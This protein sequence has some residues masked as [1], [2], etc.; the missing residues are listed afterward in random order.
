ME[1][2]FICMDG[3][4][5]SEGI[6]LLLFWKEMDFSMGILG[7]FYKI[8]ILVGGIG[9]YVDVFYN[10]EMDYL[11]DNFWVVVMGFCF[12]VM[13]M[14]DS[15]II[16]LLLFLRVGL[17]DVL[18]ILNGVMGSRKQFFGWVLEFVYVVVCIVFKVRC[19]DNMVGKLYVKN[20]KLIVFVRLV[21]GGVKWDI[22]I[23]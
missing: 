6:L 21:C 16:Y 4:V 5:G 19:M 15:Y 14:V 20:F 17:I 3:V 22:G 12:F 9:D 23:K 11:V 8:F 7:F 10:M 1:V 18:V 2:V 13:I